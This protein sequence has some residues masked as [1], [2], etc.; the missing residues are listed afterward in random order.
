MSA[1][2]IAMSQL[3]QEQLRQ[4]AEREHRE[5]LERFMAPL[6]AALV[7]CENSSVEDD[8][9]AALSVAERGIKAVDA[10]MEAR[11]LAQEPRRAPDALGEV[12]APAIPP[13]A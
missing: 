11:R 9:E 1:A 4:R 13:I 12:K 2:Q 6:V 5:R 7:K 10:H 3:A 8:I